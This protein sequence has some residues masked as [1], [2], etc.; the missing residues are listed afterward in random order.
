MAFTDWM[1]RRPVA[2]RLGLVLAEFGTQLQV[3]LVE[4]LAHFEIRMRRHR[5][6]SKTCFRSMPTSLLA[7][8]RFRSQVGGLPRPQRSQLDA[9]AGVDYVYVFVFVVLLL[10]FAQLLENRI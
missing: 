5:G 9:H 4:L 8:A 6:F 1:S 10:L 3:T 7:G 2:E